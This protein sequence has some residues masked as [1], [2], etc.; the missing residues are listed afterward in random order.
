ME[1]KIVS[2]RA[3]KCVSRGPKKIRNFASY[4][5]LV[6]IDCNPTPAVSAVLKAK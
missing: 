5:W 6:K 2:G 3:R 4:F 1:A